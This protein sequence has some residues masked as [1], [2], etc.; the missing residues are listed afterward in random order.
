MM[1][2]PKC[3]PLLQAGTNVI[4]DYFDFK[5]GTD[6][7]NKEKTPFSGGSPYLPGGTLKPKSVLRFS[8]VLLSSGIAI[9]LFLAYVR[10]WPV[11]LI[12]LI[13]VFSGVFYCEPRLNLV[14]RGVGEFLV[15][16][17]YGTLVV[18]GTYYVL[19]GIP[20]LEVIVASVPVAF[21]I[22]AV[23]YINQFPDFW[24]DKRTGKANLVVRLGRAKAV[25]WFSLILTLCY[26]WVFYWIQFEFLPRTCYLVFLS[27][28][29][30]LKAVR[31][32]KKNYRNTPGLVPAQAA[33][34]ALHL[35]AGILLIAGFVIDGLL[36]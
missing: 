4:N 22:T 3:R 18:V 28:P 25:K 1:G 36:F 35:F 11:L 16:L 8:L 23:L 33:T 32:L 19:A 20:P 31:L 13:G 14:G 34:I 17:N 26:I 15:G 21:L 6:C 29:L 7:I 2:V 10:G 12:G 24:A 5:T 27:L 9:G 30:A